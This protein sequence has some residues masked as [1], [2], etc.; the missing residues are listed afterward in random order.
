M[1]I[2]RKVVW[3][4]VILGAGLWLGSLIPSNA[5]DDLGTT[6][7]PGSV[8][9]PIVTKGYVDEKVQLSVK[10]ELAKQ[11]ITAEQIQEMIT[12]QTKTVKQDALAIKVIK[13]NSG[14]SLYAG[15]GS[16]FIVRTG[17]AVAFS[18][19]ANG[20]PDLTG[21]KDI[22]AGNAIPLNHLLI[23]PNEDGRGIKPD[24]KVASNIFVMVR[25]NYELKNADGTLDM[26]VQ[27]P[28]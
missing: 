26:T 19:T 27:V 14:Q 5:A 25:G 21:G 12:E 4:A 1:K 13:L 11:T 17:K 18:S 6:I 10:S 2:V 28:K 23:F 24:P 3:M 22:P 20:I 16:E 8:D 9:D 7:Q 15:A